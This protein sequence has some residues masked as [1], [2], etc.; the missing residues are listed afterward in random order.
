MNRS[1]NKFT[2]KIV[3]SYLV[4]ITMVVVVGFFI[5]SEIRVFL[6]AETGNETESKFVRT[7]TLLTDLYQA[8]SL[9]K[10]ALQ[11]NNTKAID[12]YALKI[13]SIYVQI[14]TIRKHTES[15]YYKELLDSVQGL[16]QKKVAN[17]KELRK[18]KEKNQVNSSLDN[19]LKEFNKMEASYG[20]ITAQSLNP[21]YNNLPKREQEILNNWASYLSANVP[22]VN[23]ETPTT[24]QIDSILDA[25]KLL[26]TQAKLKNTKTQRTMDQKEMELNRNDLQL[27]QQ[28]RSI[29]NAFEQDVILSTYNENLQKQTALRKSIRL[30]GFAALLGL[31]IVAVF[32]LLIT[33]D[34]WKLQTYRQ[35]LEKEKKYSESLL[36]SREQLISTVGHDLRTPLNTITGYSELME[37]T[38]LT[39]KQS[40]YLKNVKSASL[41]VDSLVNDLLDFSKLEAGKIKI[42][43]IPFV[44]SHLLYETAENLKEINSKKPIDLV[45]NVDSKLENPV[46]GDP[47]RIRQILTNLIGNAYKF[48][49]QGFIQI[50]AHVERE[51]S[52]R[53][54][55]VVKVIDSGIGIKKEKQEH[56]FK[57]FTQAEEQ[58][59]KKYGGY[60]LGLTI[61]KKLTELLK[62]NLSLISE[63]NM[64]STFIIHIP[65]EISKAP[66]PNKKKM[67]L[68]PKNGLTLL[69]I[70]DDSAMLKLLKE[71]CNSFGISTYIFPD[72]EHINLD[73]DLTY[74]AV[75]TDIQMP[76]TDGFQVLEKLK[77][78]HH[79][80]YK[81][82]PVI[83]MTGRRD[84]ANSAYSKAGF[85]K[86][87]QKPFTREV[88]IDTLGE[89]F[90]S[91]IHKKEE[92]RLKT[93]HRKISNLFDLDVLSS[94]LGD[95]QQAMGEVLQTFIS[96]T[97]GNM[98]QMTQALKNSDYAEIN[99]IAHRMLPMFRQL[100]AKDIVPIL[101][102]LETLKANEEK[103][104]DLSVQQN[105][106]KN[107]V[108][109]LLLAIEDYLAT[110]PTY[111][112]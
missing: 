46:L 71:L 58:T 36:K 23:S 104:K 4:L 63:E 44:L 70:D 93:K 49:D 16:L 112:D 82:Q 88:L 72:F 94:F 100:K 9:S 66:L 89:L 37:N 38:G 91:T 26:L 86:V 39:T 55:T 6:T 5:F 1:K 32:T 87:I 74:D 12:T 20:R 35:N 34:F 111:S 96:E 90:P 85:S 19:A 13:D 75:L 7:G 53:Y 57:E 80:H 68:P 22:K 48:T 92:K 11:G 99:K 10:L 15:I 41:Y 17:S 107:K 56:I 59:E 62:G 28:L 67:A 14:D 29:I 76:G 97:Q 77:S 106:L 73:A 25:S 69:I 110:S 47:F 2:F 18:L 21:N 103:S 102:N 8:E 24:H 45:L 27:S 78:G 61:S 83:A 101:E 81:N 79:L 84:L 42:E 33:R 31:M 65:F 40:T 95:N 3:L 43:K 51:T 109:I 54:F 30:A 98:E 108:I 105:D 52:E 50:D 64:G 60:G